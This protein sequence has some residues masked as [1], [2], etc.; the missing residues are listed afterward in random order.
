MEFFIS[1]YFETLVKREGKRAFNSSSPQLTRSQ[2]RNQGLCL[3]WLG[4][5]RMLVMCGSLL[6]TIFST[7]FVTHDILQQSRRRIV[8]S[9]VGS[10]QLGP[11]GNV[12]VSDLSREHLLLKENT[13]KYF[14]DVWANRIT[15]LA[16][17]L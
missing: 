6:P 8:P 15:R 17:C 1:V 9:T 4:L 3:E 2:F 11:S 14:P 5:L 12:H 7:G 10:S 16:P 13:L